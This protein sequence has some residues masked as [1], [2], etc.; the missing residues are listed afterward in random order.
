MNQLENIQKEIESL[1]ER[2][3]KVEAAKAWETSYTRKIGVAILTYL[4]ILLFFMIMKISNPFISAIV[5]TL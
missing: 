3:K 2:N 4:I 1:K 5:P